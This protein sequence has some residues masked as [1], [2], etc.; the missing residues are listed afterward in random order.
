MKKS[1]LTFLTIFLS[2]MLYAQD[3]NYNEWYLQQDDADIFVKE[4]GHGKD[5][6]IV[7]HGGF[8]A[9]HDYMLD[10]VEGLQDKF[11]FILYDQRGS[12]LSPTA[13]EN[14]TFQKNVDDLLALT[15]A[16]KLNKTK[17]F[18]H[19]MGTLVGMEFTR[20]HPDRVSHLVLSGAVLPKADS[21]KS[22]FSERVDRQVAFL[23]GRKEVTTLIQPF[24]EKGI[25]DLRSVRDLENSKL[26]HKD[27]TDYWRIGFASVNIYDMN[28][29]QL[30]KGGRAYY[31]QDA[32]VM[33][34]TVNWNYDYR[35]ILNNKVKTTIINGDHDF[36]DFNSEIFTSLLKG[37]DRIGLKIIPKAGHNSWIDHPL[38]FRKELEGALLK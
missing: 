4:I 23:S 33:T 18:C 12:L 14:L 37:Y 3:K 13:K 15:K 7:V 34:E 28:K 6:V 1:T 5:T 36:F 26:S 25:D 38:L 31:K 27:L 20:Q 21:M 10:A 8:G 17:I 16:L 19:S 35:D 2:L 11:R 32:A 22:V 30:V 24:K 9:N 29:Y